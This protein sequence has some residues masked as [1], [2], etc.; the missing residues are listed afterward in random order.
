MTPLMTRRSTGVRRREV[1]FGA[2]E[3]R[4]AAEPAPRDR[5]AAVVRVV[6]VLRDVVRAAEVL[7]AA[8]VDARPLTRV[9]A[10]LVEEVRRLPADA[11]LVVL[12]AAVMGP[13]SAA[14][15]LKRRYGSEREAPTCR[16]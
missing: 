13:V 16:A 15:R 11:P 14:C 2:A 10:F 9:G 5:E 3:R 1:R 6:V 8:D 4:G 7:L 12:R